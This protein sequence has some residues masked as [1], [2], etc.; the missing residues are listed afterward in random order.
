[1]SSKTRRDVMFSW[2]K[3]RLKERTSYDGIVVVGVSLIALFL[4]PFVKYAA[5]ATLAYGIWTL[6]RKE[7]K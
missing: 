6:V 4:G 7:E 2:V 1:M 3:N 5:L